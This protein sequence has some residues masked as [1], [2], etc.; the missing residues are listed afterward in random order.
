MVDSTADPGSRP[1]FGRAEPNAGTDSRS[2]VVVRR[3]AQRGRTTTDW[4]DAWHSFNFGSFREPA[5]SSFG[6]LIVFNDDIV[7]PAKGF[8]RHPHRDLEIVTW[9]VTGRVY[10]RDSVGNE[11]ELHPGML[12]QMTAGQGIV[13]SEINPSRTEIARWVQMWVVPDRSG[14]PPKY[15]DLDAS[16]AL[17]GG[18]LV[19]LVGRRQPDAL[20]DHHQRDAVL[21]A[22]WLPASRT[23]RLPH[24]PMVH[25]YVT[26]GAVE[27]EGVGLLGEG[28]PAR[29]STGDGEQLTAGAGTGAEV[30][31]WEMHSAVADDRPRNSGR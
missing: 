7:Q 16:D 19:P 1:R 15:Q 27:I 13:H 23:V 31:V 22:G 2:G 9:P 8:G 30:L 14:L 12:Q 5:N 6:L 18:E 29:L 3:S 28:D 11:G 25:C 26:R 10:H 24:A 17:A 21:W 20:A 4:L